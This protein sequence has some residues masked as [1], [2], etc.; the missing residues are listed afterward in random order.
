ML[1]SP[2]PQ[3]GAGVH[4]APEGR[5]SMTKSGTPSN[6]LDYTCN[7][8][9]LMSMGMGVD[10]AAII[11]RWLDEPSSRPFPLHALTLAT[12]M[13]GDEYAAT[14]AAMTRHILPLLAE[15]GVRYVQLARAGQREEDGYVVLDDSRA[16]QRMHMTGPWR[17][18]D[19]LAA[20]GTVPQIVSGRRLCSYRAKGSVLDRWIEA[21]FGGEPHRH[22]IGF[23]AEEMRRVERDSSYTTNARDPWYPLIEWGWDRTAC[24]D[25]LRARFGIEW[26]RSCCSYCPF[27]AGPDTAG[28]V[29]RWSAEPDKGADALIREHLALCLNPRSMLFGKRTAWSLAREHQLTDVIA[30]AEQRLAAATWTVYDVRRVYQA[31]GGNQAV[32]G[33]GWRAVAPLGSGTR[34]QLTAQLAAMDGFELGAL[35]IARVWIRRASAPYP[36]PEHLLTVGPAGVAAKQRPG[37]AKQWASVLNPQLALFDNLTGAAGR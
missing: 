13:T 7:S 11:T 26:P 1:A 4:P 30:L 33:Q 16:P 36:S 17:L 25:Y 23:A 14:A 9:V 19:E 22:V 12:A 34:E 29:A 2:F 3:N 20:T 28:L 6:P 18:S 21:E 37:F 8:R 5:D 27:S 15:H 10:S 31:K 32:K 35:D 24:Q